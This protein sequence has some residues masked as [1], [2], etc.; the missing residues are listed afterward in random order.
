MVLAEKLDLRRGERIDTEQVF[1]FMTIFY[2]LTL[3]PAACSS[4]TTS[5]PILAS[6][7]FNMIVFG[8]IDLWTRNFGQF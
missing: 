5:M 8:A 3:R 2:A 4:C 7:C 1:D 6:M